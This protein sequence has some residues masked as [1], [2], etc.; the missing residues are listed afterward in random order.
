[1]NDSQATLPRKQLTFVHF[2]LSDIHLK[3]TPRRDFGGPLLHLKI[4]NHCIQTM[5]SLQHL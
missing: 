1:M 4:K 3:K 2:L 5:F